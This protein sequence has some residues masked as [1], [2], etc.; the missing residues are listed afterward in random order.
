MKKTLNEKYILLTN[1]EEHLNF[2][3]IPKHSFDQTIILEG[4]FS[5]EEAFIALSNTLNSESLG[6]VGFTT[7][8][9]KF[10]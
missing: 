4:T 6:L 8:L 5:K 3:D 1:L 2:S 7:E 9:L 10:F